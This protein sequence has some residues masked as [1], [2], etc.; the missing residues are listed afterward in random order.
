MRKQRALQIK[1]SKDKLQKQ[2]LPSMPR[3]PYVPHMPLMPPIHPPYYSPPQNYNFQN[4]PIK[5][6]SLGQHSPD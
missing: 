5:K 4:P 3:I 6:Y 2:N 1:I